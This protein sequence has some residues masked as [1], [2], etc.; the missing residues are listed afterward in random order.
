[1]ST[2]SSVV[3]PESEVRLA[4]SLW[5]AITCLP[6]ATTSPGSPGVKALGAKLQRETSERVLTDAQFRSAVAHR[7]A[8]ADPPDADGG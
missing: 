7:R 5:D 4:R 1:M 6:S 8:I 2:R 3:A